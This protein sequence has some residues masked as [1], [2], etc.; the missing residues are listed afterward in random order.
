M[1]KVRKVKKRAAVG[2]TGF[3]LCHLLAACADTAGKRPPEDGGEGALSGETQLTVVTTFAGGDGNAQNYRNSYRQWETQTGNR[4]VD[5]SAGSDLT[6]R[7]RV[8]ADFETGSEP[9]VLF[10]FYG[11]EADTLIEA[12]KVVCVEEIRL[13]YPGYAANISE[14]KIPCSEVDGRKYAVPVT[15]YWEAL[16][17]NT[18]ILEE[19]GVPLPGADAT[20]DE[21]LAGCARIREAGYVPIA[22]A[23]GSI[24]HYWWEYAIFN[25]TGPESHLEIPIS[26]D[27]AAGQAWVDGL[28]DIRSLYEAGYFPANTLSASDDETF[29]MF[30]DG[31]AAFLLDGSWKAGQIV[32]ACQADPADPDTLD[33]KKLSDYSVTYLPGTERRQAG[34][35]IGGFSMGY[36][37]TRKAWEDPSKREAAVS[38]VSFMTGDEVARRFSGYAVDALLE[39]PQAQGAADA[40]QER[41]PQTGADSPVPN[42]SLQEAVWELLRGSSSL[43]EALQDRFDGGCRTPTFAGMPDIVTGR[44]DAKEAVEKGLRI[45]HGS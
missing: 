8:L 9:D 10:F 22:A 14:E 11:G 21:F 13:S 20:W 5:R 3:L 39:E 30:M 16:F 41:E 4:I 26:A 12:G 34:D 6:F 1:E 32:S 42:N 31:K 17:V 15:G 19:A 35:L 43:T 7:S 27:T 25:H 29:A 18:R 33:Q 45:Y 38:F 2:L 44:A 36:Y 23:L 40:L 37:I 28:S 24:P